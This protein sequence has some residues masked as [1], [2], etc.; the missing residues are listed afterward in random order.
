VTMRHTWKFDLAADQR[1]TP[2][3]C[4]TKKIPMR[5]TY[6]VADQKGERKDVG[7]S[8]SYVWNDILAGQAAHS[9][10]IG[11][12]TPEER[13]KQYLATVAALIGVGPRDELEAMLA[14][15]MIAGHNAAMEC[16]R[17]AMLPE[18]S[19]EGR[20]GNLSQANKLSR[21]FAA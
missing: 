2:R 20:Q 16:F 13:D 14:A 9:L 21:A 7:G 6:N 19:A 4:M 10:W 17:R 18:R 15:Q 12:S 1:H 11:N 3:K 5:V 8:M